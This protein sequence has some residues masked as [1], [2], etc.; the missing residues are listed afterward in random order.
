ME[1][2]WKAWGGISSVQLTLPVLL[3]EGVNKRGLTL[4][5]LS[6]MLSY[7]PARL[8][9]LYPQKGTIKLGADADLMVVDLD[10]EWM[11]TTE[12]LFYKNKFSA[13]VGSTFKDE[14]E[15]TMIRGRTVYQNGQIVADP[16]YGKLL[17]R[18]YPYAY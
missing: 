11:L 9:G 2:I 13:Y 4:T 16:G 6:R 3:S 5:A 12:Q 10:K 18:S 1:D 15:H 14:V 17:R 8:F 7:S